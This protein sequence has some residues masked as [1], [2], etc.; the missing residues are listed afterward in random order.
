MKMKNRITL[1]QIMAHKEH[2]DQRLI[3]INEDLI[4][5]AS[6]LSAANA[7]ITYR[8]QQ[9]QKKVHSLHVDCQII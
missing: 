1:N 7:Q 9:S 8:N 5:Q 2:F 3:E 4:Q 6:I